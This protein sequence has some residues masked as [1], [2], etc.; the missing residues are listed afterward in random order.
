MI[1]ITQLCPLQWGHNWQARDAMIGIWVP[2]GLQL[3]EPSIANHSTTRLAGVWVGF[4]DAGKALYPNLIISPID[5][6]SS[7]S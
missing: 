5:C 1:D 3:V 7:R 4:R 2:L 6:P